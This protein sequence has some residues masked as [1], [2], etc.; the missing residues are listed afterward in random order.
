MPAYVIAHIDVK[1]P[2]RYEDYKKMSPVSIQKFGGRF[3][4]RGARAEVL[5]GT[6]EPKRL[7]L[8]EFPSAEAARQWYAS[9]DYAPAKA[10]RQSTST[11]DLVLV[12]G[13]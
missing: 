3:I 11:G 8:V 4:A 2:V 6:W 12:D 9:D 1:D 10:L 7:V 13:I 5:E